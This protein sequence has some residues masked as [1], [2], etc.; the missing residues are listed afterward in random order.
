[1]YY[2]SNKRQPERRDV[3]ERGTKRNLV[4]FLYEMTTDTRKLKTIL[5]KK[6]SL[7]EEKPMDF[8]VTF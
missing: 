8:E 1:M 6:D 5:E 7:V 3:Y 2:I 4:R